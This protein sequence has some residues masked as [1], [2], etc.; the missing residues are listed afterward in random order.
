MIQRAI[1]EQ[2]KTDLLDYRK[3]ILVYGPR[4]VGKTNY[5]NTFYFST[6]FHLIQNQ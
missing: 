1:A 3:I 6:Y 2:I 5:I 4:Q